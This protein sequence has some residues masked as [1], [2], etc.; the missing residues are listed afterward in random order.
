[1]PYE[2]ISYIQSLNLV[3]YCLIGA[4]VFIWLFRFTFDIIFYGRLAFRKV[5][6]AGSSSLPI[7]IFI[8]ERKIG[9][10]HV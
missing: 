8:V 7:T 1:M 9:R 3:D 10:A 4:I 5:A 2:I 6:P